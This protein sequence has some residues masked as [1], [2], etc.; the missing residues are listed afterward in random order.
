VP[1]SAGIEPVSFP[2]SHT[3]LGDCTATIRVSEL[4]DANRWEKTWKPTLQAHQRGDGFWEWREHISRA[5]TEKDWLCVSIVRGE[6]LDAMLSLKLERGTSRLEPRTD[7][8]YIEYVGVAP[9]NQ[10]PPIGNKQI[11]GLGKLLVKLAVRVSTSLK[12]EGRIGLHAKPDVEDFYRRLGLVACERED[13]GDGIWLYFE[14]GP[15][16]ARKLLGV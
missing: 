10:S 5:L 9:H 4:A 7:L 13:T 14:A 1:F 3:I 12:L 15:E 8:V 2:V 11:K 6:E 16:E